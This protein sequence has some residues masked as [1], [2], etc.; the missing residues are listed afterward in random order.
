MSEG[1]PIY[2]RAWFWLAIAAA[3]I[4]SLL[5]VLVWANGPDGAYSLDARRFMNNR[6]LFERAASEL[7]AEGGTELE[8]PGVKAV[9]LWGEGGEA[10]VEFTTGGFGLAPSSSYHGVYYSADGEPA[11]FQNTDVPLGPSREGWI[12]HGEGDNYGETRHINE[13]W[14]T[15]YA[16]F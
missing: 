12:W 10:I 4:F 2:R 3:I 16:S 1:K 15:F 11:A 9:C 13:N 6:E 14:Y 7:L 5:R 8:I